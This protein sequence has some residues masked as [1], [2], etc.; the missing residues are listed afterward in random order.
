MEFRAIAASAITAAMLLGLLGVGIGILSWILN[1]LNQFD[2]PWQ[3]QLVAASL[4]VLLI[5]AGAAKMF[6]GE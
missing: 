3:A 5:A 2:M 1:I 4:V 6:S